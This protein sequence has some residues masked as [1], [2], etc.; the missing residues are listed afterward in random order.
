V[1]LGGIGGVAGISWGAV[2]SAMVGIA[3]IGLLNFGV[4][5]ALALVIA[6]RARDVPRGESKTLPGAVLRRFLRRPLEFFY[7]PRD[8]G[9]PA[10]TSQH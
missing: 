6:L 2:A 8:A 9:P 1:G 3:L 7:P 4:S 5:F 10:A